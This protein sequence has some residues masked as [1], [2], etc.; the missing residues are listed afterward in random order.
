M[1]A[2]SNTPAPITIVIAA[3]VRLYREGLATILSAQP[4]LRVVGT[5]GT[6]LE[7]GTAV[8]HHRPDVVL[9]DVSLENALVLM[10]ELRAK[11]STGRILAFAVQ[12]DITTILECADA[13]ADGFVTASG[14][15][16]ELVEAIARTA[17]G[18][19]L[20]SPRIAAQL[21]RRAAHRARGQAEPAAAAL[22]NREQ[23]VFSLLKQGRSNKEIA[24]ALHIS[25]ATVKN[26]VHH[27]LEKLHVA[28]RGQAAAARDH[29]LA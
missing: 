24:S 2:P 21:L 8:R 3:A 15:V 12:E 20:C 29:S 1:E 16:S 14:S 26:H 13:G 18:E 5:A 9:I 6:H 10:R 25:E 22:T 27:V 4:H 19:L 11:D 28:T 7:A 23:Q 17:A